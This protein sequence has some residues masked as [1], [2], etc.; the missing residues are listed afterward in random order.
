MLKDAVVR[1]L[2]ILEEGGRGAG[3]Y[4]DLEGIRSRLQ[5]KMLRWSVQVRAKLSSK[6]IAS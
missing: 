4:R 3:L 5:V 2:E 1:G 6:T